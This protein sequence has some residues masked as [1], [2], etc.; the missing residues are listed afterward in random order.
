MRFSCPA[1]TQLEE[2][3]SPTL[4]GL[5]IDDTQQDFSTEVIYP[6]GEQS[7]MI[8]LCEGLSMLM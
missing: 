1:R 2:L 3:I 5:G 4:A 7:Y 6:Q 8:L